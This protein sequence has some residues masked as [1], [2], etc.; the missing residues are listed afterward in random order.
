MYKDRNVVMLPTEKAANIGDIVSRNNRSELAIVNPLTINDPNKNKHQ[1][2]HLYITS[3]EEIKEGDWCILFKDHK[4]YLYQSLDTDNSNAKKIIATTDE[5]ITAD[6]STPGTTFVPSIPKSFLQS[7]VKAYNDGNPITEVMV[8]YELPPELKIKL[9]SG[10]V[11]RAEESD[12]IPKLTD[13]NEIIIHL[14]KPKMY[15]R[16]DMILFGEYVRSTDKSI[17]TMRTLDIFKEWNGLKKT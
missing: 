3:D 5:Q 8:E 11:S 15:S 9:I 4:N 16:E 2:E 10:R 12:C 13:N 7:Y 17:P 6:F 1:T 14:K